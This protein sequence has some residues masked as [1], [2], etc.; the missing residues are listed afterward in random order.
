VDLSQSFGTQTRRFV[1][2]L[3][4]GLFASVLVNGCVSQVTCETP[5][6]PCVQSGGPAEAAVTAVAAG[7][8]WAGSGGCAIAGC[9]TPYV[10]NSGS[11]LCE[12]MAC[13]EGSGSCPPG[14]QCDSLTS[15]C[16]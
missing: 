5:A 12:H 4:G 1:V 2:A 16:R 15:T 13:G 11:G 14:T 6:D 3:L 8:L 10:C 7:A 9:R